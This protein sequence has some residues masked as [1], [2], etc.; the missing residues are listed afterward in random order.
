MKKDDLLIKEI[1]NLDNLPPIDDNFEPSALNDFRNKLSYIPDYVEKNLCRK[2]Q[3]AELSFSQKTRV[4]RDLDWLDRET[5]KNLLLQMIKEACNDND[6][7]IVSE[8]A[9][10]HYIN[11]DKYLDLV[12]NF[13]REAWLHIY[14]RYNSSETVASK[15]IQKT[16]TIQEIF[17]LCNNKCDG[18]RY[19]KTI[20]TLA[21]RLKL[22]PASIQQWEEIKE[23]LPPDP[24]L[25]NLFDILR[26]KE[27][28]EVNQQITAYN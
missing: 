3:D 22:A 26:T 16:Q 5:K 4:L 9:H 15:I 20:T 7:I 13:S 14:G 17:K 10:D 19:T 24:D 23:N 27:R 1:I 21:P 6:I 18:K 28:S 25:E 12:D 2:I 8:L 11:I